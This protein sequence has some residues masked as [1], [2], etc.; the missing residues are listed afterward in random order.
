M[1]IKALASIEALLFMMFF[2][3]L[4]LK[5][6]VLILCNGIELRVPSSLPIIQKLS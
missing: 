4:L 1:I 6:L 3:E 2:Q 5:L